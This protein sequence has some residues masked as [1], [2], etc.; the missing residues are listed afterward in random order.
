MKS[1]PLPADPKA[2]TADQPSAGCVGTALPVLR[3]SVDFR[4]AKVELV[5]EPGG[6]LRRYV[7][8]NSQ[9][10][11]VALGQPKRREIDPLSAKQPHFELR[12]SELWALAEHQ[13]LASLRLLYAK[14]AEPSGAATPA[15]P[16][17]ASTRPLGQLEAPSPADDSVRGE[18][19]YANP[20]SDGTFEIGLLEDGCRVRTI[21]GIDLARALLVAEAKLRDTILVERQGDHN[22]VIREERSGSHGEGTRT[23]KRGRETFTITRESPTAKFSDGAFSNRLR[24]STSSAS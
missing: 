15:L 12:T 3:R 4:D 2:S 10:L 7:V 14:L 24:P 8:L 11:R 22:V 20:T 17:R 18:L 21:Q 19:L 9:R 16:R 6:R 23:L 5:L 13:A 1:E